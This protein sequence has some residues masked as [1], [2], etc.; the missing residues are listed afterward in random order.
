VPR[1]K[2]SSADP[3][4]SSPGVVARARRRTVVGLL[5]VVVAAVVTVAACSGTSG[6][7]TAAPPGTV[8]SNGQANGQA[9]YAAKCASCHG[10]DLRG[11]DRGPSHLSKV[12]EP[13]HHSDASFRAAIAN[14]ARQH[15]WAFGDMPPVSGLSPEEVAAIIAYVRTVQGEKGFEPYPPQ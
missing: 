3:M 6:S 8:S 10:A 11:T 7:G 15:H 14:G 4:A 13:G 1:T 2:T 9:L 12:Y 5:P